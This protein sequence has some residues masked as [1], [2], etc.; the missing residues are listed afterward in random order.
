MENASTG[1]SALQRWLGTTWY[2][3][4]ARMYSLARSTAAM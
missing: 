2:T 3:S 4:P 1:Q